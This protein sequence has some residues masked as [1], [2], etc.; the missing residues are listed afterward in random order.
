[1]GDCQLVLRYFALKDKGNIRGSM[2]AMLDRAME[3][4]ITEQ[5]GAK[6]KKMYEERFTFLYNLFDGRPFRLLPDERGHDRVSAAIYDASMVA[7]NGYW[8]HRE[9]IKAD[10]TNV[11]LRMKRATADT[12]IVHILT[13]Q[14]NEKESIRAGR[15]NGERWPLPHGGRGQF[16]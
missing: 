8:K 6:W 15:A 2:K 13:G 1:M 16:G 12:D 11:Q 4:E 3:T 10:K 7:I 14:Q 9:Q 5:V